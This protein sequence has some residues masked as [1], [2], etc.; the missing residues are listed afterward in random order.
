[1]SFN[2]PLGGLPLSNNGLFAGLPTSGTPEGQNLC[3]QFTYEGT[4][5]IVVTEGYLDAG[6]VIQAANEISLP[7]LS[8]P[9][10]DEFLL[11]RMMA[12]DPQGR[13]WT[14]SEPNV[15]ADPRYNATAWPRVPL[16]ISEVV[17][18]LNQHYRKPSDEIRD[19]ASG[20]LTDAVLATATLQFITTPVDTVLT[21]TTSVEGRFV[22]QRYAYLDNEIIW[23][24]AVNGTQ[25][26]CVRARLGTLSTGYL[27]GTVVTYDRYCDPYHSYVVAYAETID[28]DTRARLVYTPG[29]TPLLS[30]QNWLPI[31]QDQDGDWESRG[32]TIFLRR[33]ANP[34]TGANRDNGAVVIHLNALTGLWAG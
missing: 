29:A 20:V 34:G 16:R 10:A 6:D 22:P 13:Q 30:D 8:W 31:I 14:Y 27:A 12:W 15:P 32:F 24:E 4:L 28:A 7:A 9:T 3:T 18:Q 21:F 2:V 26:S 33:D 5:D 17:R 1:M 23:V 11:N 25:I 19:R